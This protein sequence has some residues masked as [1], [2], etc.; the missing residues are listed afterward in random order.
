MLLFC[1]DCGAKNVLDVDPATEPVR[2]RCQACRYQNTIWRRG[3]GPVP[4]AALPPAPAPA[5]EAEE[6]PPLLDH[7]QE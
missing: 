2:F 1:E 4:G 7:D 6:P 5:T 3:R